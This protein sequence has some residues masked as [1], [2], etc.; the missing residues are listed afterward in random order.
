MALGE[1][2]GENGTNTTEKKSNALGVVGTILGAVGTAGV[3]TNGGLGGIL[4]GGNTPQS[5]DYVTKDRFFETTIAQ[6]DKIWG[7]VVDTQRTQAETNLAMCGEIGDLKA[8][9]AVANAINDAQ[10]RENAM[11]ADYENQLVKCY[12]SGQNFVRANPMISPNQIGV[13]YAADTRV[14]E[15]YSAYHDPYRRGYGVDGISCCG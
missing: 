5:S 2:V 13:G 14:L 7:V 3:L 10:N 6:N 12:I 8:S 1:I 4:G 9:I 15:S 11:R